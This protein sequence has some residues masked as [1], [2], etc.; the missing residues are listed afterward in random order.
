MD[1]LRRLGCRDIDGDESVLCALS[2][3][4]IGF[5]DPASFRQR[6]CFLGC[7]YEHSVVRL[8]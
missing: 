3:A 5:D 6:L 8:P 7:T 4:L 1:P 2:K